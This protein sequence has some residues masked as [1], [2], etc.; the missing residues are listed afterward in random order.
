MNN[1]IIKGIKQG[2]GKLAS[3]TA[4]KLS[5]ESQRILE[6]TISGKELLGLNGGVS[7]NEL[8][9]QQQE[10]EI[11][12]QEEIR[13]IKSEMGLGRDVEQE[14]EEVRDQKEKEEEEKERYFEQMKEQQEQERQRQ[15]EEQNMSVDLLAPKKHH[16]DKG[17]NKHKTQQPDVSQMSQTVEF[18]TKPN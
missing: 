17:G 14:V 12:K 9:H 6:A 3:E 8:L 13:K 18:K 10:D 1:Q 11:K 4:E 5:E 15:I 2:F 16:K 7:N